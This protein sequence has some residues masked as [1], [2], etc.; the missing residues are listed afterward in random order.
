MH[1][2]QFV[3]VLNFFVLFFSAVEKIFRKFLRML[4]M[5][6]YHGD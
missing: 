6:D 2:T 5:T 3:R 4:R 1:A